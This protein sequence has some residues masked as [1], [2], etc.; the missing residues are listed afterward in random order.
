MLLIRSLDPLETGPEVVIWANFVI[1][2]GFFRF[3][4]FILDFD[5]LNVL[6][7]RLVSSILRFF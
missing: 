3:I 2:P 1:F 5:F 6:N 4:I 7:S